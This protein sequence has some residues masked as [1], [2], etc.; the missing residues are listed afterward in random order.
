MQRGCWCCKNA[1]KKNE[2]KEICHDYS[3]KKKNSS[4]TDQLSR[5]KIN[6]VG[7]M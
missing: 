5:S 4:Q 2:K 6:P 7:K 1:N 3:L